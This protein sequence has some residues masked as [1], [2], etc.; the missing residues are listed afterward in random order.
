MLLADL[1]L[2]C[3]RVV[4][5]RPT[6]SH[7]RAVLRRRAG[8]LG[9]G[10]GRRPRRDYIKISRCTESVS[11]ARCRA[12]ES[13]RPAAARRLAR[14]LRGI[15]LAS[16]RAAPRHVKERSIE[17]KNRRHQVGTDTGG[18]V[19]G[20]S[21][22][23]PTPHPWTCA[24]ATAAARGLS[25]KGRGRLRAPPRRERRDV[26]I[27]EAARRGRG[28]GRAAPDPP[29]RIRLSMTLRIAGTIRDTSPLAR[30]PATAGPSGC[31]RRHVRLVEVEVL[32]LVGRCRWAAPTS[33]CEVRRF[34]GLANCC[35]RFVVVTSPSRR[36][37]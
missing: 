1:G 21:P 20:I 5:V 34:T 31:V 3:V 13:R 17:S 25:P 35:H 7:P 6:D 32:D 26:A 30:P 4:C 8:L 10:A 22:A 2:T 15:G 14:A 18:G 12:S 24:N 16:H 28:V 36:C 9:T 27:G 11:F 23:P 29:S 37:Y 33:F 19:R